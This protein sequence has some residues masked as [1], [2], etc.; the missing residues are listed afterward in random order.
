[1]PIYSLEGDQSGLPKTSRR[2]IPFETAQLGM[3]DTW[4]AGNG[5]LIVPCRVLT[6]QSP[7]WV[8]D[9]VGQVSVIAPGGDLQLTRYVPERFPGFASQGVDERVMYCSGVQSTECG[10]V[11]V[12]NFQGNFANPRTKWGETLWRKYTATFESWPFKV[13]TDA[14]ADDVVISGGTYGGARELTR[15]VVRSRSA[16][17]KEQP[18]PAGSQGFR[19]T[20]GGS[21]GSPGKKIGQVAYRAI[22]YQDVTYTWKR[23]PIGWPPPIGWT[24]FNPGIPWPPPVGLTAADPTK[25]YARDAFLNAVND[26]WWD[27]AAPDGY[28]WPPG[29]LLYVGYD[30]SNRYYDAAGQWVCDVSFRFK[31]KM[32]LDADGFRG[33]WNYAMTAAGK[34]VYINLEGYTGGATDTPPYKKLDFNKLFRYAAS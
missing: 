31:A 30:D 33:G 7:L 13:L 3:M 8:V 27:V 9:M 4:G 19:D 29:T 14:Q 20:T 15:Y 18:I 34:W 17:T 21:S 6:G 10:D 25:R 5:N 22:Q 12:P 2:L 26:D 1:M 16:S 32:G 28:A 11:P 24:G 23:I